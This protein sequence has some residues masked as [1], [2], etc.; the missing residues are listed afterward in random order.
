MPYSESQDKN[1]EY[2]DGL[3]RC[4]TDRLQLCFSDYNNQRAAARIDRGAADH[5]VAVD[6]RVAEG[7][8]N[9]EGA[10]YFVTGYL[11]LVGWLVVPQH[12]RKDKIL[13]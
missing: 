11:H 10:D 4:L 13:L 2:Q 6:H 7:V 1:C 12:R 8:H 5:R 9:M 3:K